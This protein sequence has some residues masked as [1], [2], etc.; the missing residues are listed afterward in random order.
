M[1]AYPLSH[2]TQNSLFESGT[3]PVIHWV[4]NELLVKLTCLIAQS[5][6][7]AA[8]D[9]ENVPA[10]QSIQVSALEVEKVPPEQ[11]EHIPSPPCEN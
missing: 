5:V 9:D 6:Q 1:K 4:H 7:V 11:S 8:P 2:C 10:G 3:V